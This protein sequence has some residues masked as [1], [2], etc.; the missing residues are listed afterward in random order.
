MSQIRYW[1]IFHPF[2]F[3]LYPIL[4]FYSKNVAEL[5]SVTLVRPTIFLLGLV[6]VLLLIVRI[7]TKN[8]EHAAVLVSWWLILLL[9][10][11]YSERFPVRIQVFQADLD[12]LEDR[13]YFSTLSRPYDFIDAQA[14]SKTTCKFALTPP[15]N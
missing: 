9:Y 1:R 12:L 3:V 11:N 8:W 10:V 15:G 2:F 4:A 13:P 7:Y 5:P 14:V 6:I